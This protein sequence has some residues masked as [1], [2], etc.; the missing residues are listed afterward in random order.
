MTAFKIFPLW[1]KA[2]EAAEQGDLDPLINALQSDEPMPQAAREALAQNEVECGLTHALTHG[3]GHQ[4][5][6][7]KKHGHRADA[8]HDRGMTTDDSPKHR[9]GRRARAQSRWEPSAG[10]RQKVRASSHLI[11]KL[12]AGKT[13]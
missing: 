2:I 13:R 11:N 8:G 1:I 4:Q 9:A 3:D 12:P 10:S 6:R 7:R 5:E